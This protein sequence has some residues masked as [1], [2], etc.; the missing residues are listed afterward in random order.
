VTPYE[1]LRRTTPVQDATKAELLRTTR[2]LE[3][4]ALQSPPPAVAATLQDSRYFT[5]RTREVY[6]SL[7]AA[8]A[9]ARLHARGLRAWLAPGVVGVSLDEDD[10]LVDEWVVVLPGVDPV[11]FAATDLRVPDCEDDD[12]CFS[13]GVSRDPALV[14]SCGHLLGI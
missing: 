8:G 14:Q 13:Y 9:P 11:V 4:A 5:D 7:A 12:R 3:R 2:R 10:P 1:L 6:A